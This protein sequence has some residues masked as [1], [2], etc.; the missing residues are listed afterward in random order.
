MISYH[1]EPALDVPKLSRLRDL[2]DRLLIQCQP[3]RAAKGHASWWQWLKPMSQFSF[4]M[5]SSGQLPLSG[6][7]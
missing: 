1:S 7:S 3:E 4:S 6:Q 2:E 5:Q